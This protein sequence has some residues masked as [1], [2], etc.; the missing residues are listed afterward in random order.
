M[1]KIAVVCGAGGLI[2]AHMA[3]RLRTDGYFVRGLG[4]SPW[5]EKRHG[6][7][8]CDEYW[9]CD[10]RKPQPQFFENAH[11]VYQFACEVG[12]LGYILDR[13]NDADCLRNSTLIDINVLE[14]CRRTKVGK[15]FFASSACVYPDL[16]RPLRERDA[17]TA[18]PLNEF[19]AQK[20]FAERLYQSYAQ[21]YGMQVR[22]GRIFNCYGEGMT[23]GGP[24]EKVVAALCRKVA[25]AKDGDTIE[26]WGSGWQR[27]SFSNVNGVVDLVGRLMRSEYDSPLNLGPP[28]STSI[29]AV[30]AA[31]V[32]FSGKSLL[33]KT[34]CGPVGSS[35]ISCDATAAEQIVG[36]YPW[37]FGLSLEQVFRWVEKQ[38][39]DTSTAT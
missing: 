13:A 8:P 5:N 39:L 29:H 20:L 19:A 12:G 14:A 31:L 15:I 16:G 10:L 36:S 38:L 35:D 18:P 32:R 37:E 7:N 1:I 23:V 27:R 30:L 33:G 3:R 25:Q 11:E 4:R 17:W 24:R 28:N 22:I 34:M 9:T 6:P 21:N 2:G 26:V